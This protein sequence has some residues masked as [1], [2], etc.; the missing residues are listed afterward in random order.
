M[1]Q[2]PRA[3]VRFQGTQVRF[4]TARSQIPGMPAPSSMVTEN[5]AFAFE[6]DFQKSMRTWDF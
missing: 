2:W 4:P 5:E 1:V 3:C 6:F